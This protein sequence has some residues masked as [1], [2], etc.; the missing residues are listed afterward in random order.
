TDG[1]GVLA[2]VGELVDVCRAAGVLLRRPA[3]PAVPVP[4]HVQGGA[5]GGAGRRGSVGGR[6]GGSERA[7][8]LLVLRTG[9]APAGVVAFRGPEGARCGEG[10]GVAES[11]VRRG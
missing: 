7:A 2:A 10:L 5:G 4:V 8:A 9:A 6:F 11:G 3:A 1:C